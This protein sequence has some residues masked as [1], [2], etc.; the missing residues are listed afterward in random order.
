VVAQ[1]ALGI[2]TLVLAVPLGLG[3]LHQLMGLAVLT[4]VLAAAHRTGRSMA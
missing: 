1:V 4:V 2:V 3:V